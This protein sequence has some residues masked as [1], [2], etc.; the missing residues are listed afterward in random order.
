[1]QA[2]S[3]REQLVVL[4][5][6]VMG[7]RYG[8]PTSVVREVLRAVQPARLPG[9]PAVV[10][11]VINVRGQ[12]AALVDLRARFGLPPAPLAASDV[13]VLC[14]PAGRLVAF[15]ADRTEGL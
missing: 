8:V 13:F 12:L 3:T 4:V 10:M 6:E 9:A 11:G 14:E 7:H 15:R 2:A 5:F 1:M